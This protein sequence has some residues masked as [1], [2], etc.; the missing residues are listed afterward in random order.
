MS[1]RTV[2]R[3]QK[4]SPTT[5]LCEPTLRLIAP[6]TIKTGSA[7]Q[8][9]GGTPNKSSVSRLETHLRAKLKL[10]RVERCCRLSKGWQRVNARSERVIRYSKVRPIEDVEPSA[11]NCKSTPSVR[12]IRLLK[13]KSSEAKSKRRSLFRRAP[14]GQSLLFVSYDH[15]GA[16]R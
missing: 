13:R 7:G 1:N 4:L 3:Y 10:S 2:E 16:I 12:W 6:S 9:A 8:F 15:C 5:R 11:S 14:T